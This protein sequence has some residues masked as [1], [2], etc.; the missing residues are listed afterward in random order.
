MVKS[1]ERF[2]HGEH[3]EKACDLLFLQRSFPDWTIT[4]AFYAALHFISY[5]I[6]PFTHKIASGESLRFD[7]IEQWQQFK[8]YTSNKRHELLKELVAVHCDKIYPDYD[9]LL[10]LSMT[11]RYHQYQQDELLAGKAVRL[12]KEIKKACQPT[13]L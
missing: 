4:T 9:W 10:S 7:N 6:F 2:L 3:N 5:K 12:M 13:K 8:R 11:A 1:N